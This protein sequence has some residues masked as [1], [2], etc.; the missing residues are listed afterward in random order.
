MKTRK[1]VNHSTLMSE[2]IN[3]LA[4][5]FKPSV[6][7]IKACVETLIEKEYIERV[8]GKDVYIYVA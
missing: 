4:S 6:Q 7:K 2:T 8:D 5:R 1:Q 3:H